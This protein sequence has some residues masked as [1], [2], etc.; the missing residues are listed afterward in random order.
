MTT[1]EKNSKQSSFTE[2][3]GKAERITSKSHKDKLY[4]NFRKNLRI[5]R[6]REDISGTEL[7]TK[8]NLKRGTRIIDLEYGRSASPSF[9]E[10]NAI[11]NYFRVTIDDLVNKEALI[12]FTTQQKEAGDE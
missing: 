12:S 11:A 8:L 6:A 2:L 1:N 5:L 3:G 7:A 10:L 9:E 4:Y